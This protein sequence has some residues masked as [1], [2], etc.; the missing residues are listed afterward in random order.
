M[1]HVQ[2][3]VVAGCRRGREHAPIHLQQTVEK[4]A[5]DWDLTLRRE[6]ATMKAAKVRE[7]FY[8]F[9]IDY[10]AVLIIVKH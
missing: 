1:A 7:S 6:N 5:A 2:K 9:T 4:T 10:T 8:L 3:R